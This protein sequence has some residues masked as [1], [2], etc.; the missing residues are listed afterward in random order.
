V[1]GTNL[2]DGVAP[3]PEVQTRVVAPVEAF[4]S[5]LAARIVATSEVELDGRR[6]RVRTV[7]TNLGNLVGDALLWQ[8]RERA[9]EFGAPLPQVALQ[10][11]GGIRNDNVIPPGSLSELT[12]FS[13]LPFSNFVA[14]VPNLSREQFKELLENA[15]SRVEFTDG[16]FAQIAGFEFSYT[17]TATTAQVVNTAGEVLTPGTRVRSVVLDDGTVIVADGV[18]QPGAG[19]TIATIDFLAN[20]GDQYPYRG[21]PF[22]ILTGVTYQLALE[23]YLRTG[24]NG[25]VTAA[26]Y[27]A[28]PPAPPARIT[29]LP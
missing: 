27:P 3:D 21:V 19:I 9:A 8:A 1:A 11:S 24:L 5:E 15:V 17:T 4:V 6:S 25:V 18:V 26:A 22:T 23:N 13:V 7:E 16:R 20:G 14:V 2:P 28:T 29:R 12:T 10:N